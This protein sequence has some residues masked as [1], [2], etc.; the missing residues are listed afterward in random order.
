MSI[1][2]QENFNLDELEKLAAEIFAATPSPLA[3]IFQ[4]W[5]AMGADQNRR[6][7]KAVENGKAA[8]QQYNDLVALMR[9]QLD[10]LRQNW[11][12]WRDEQDAIIEE[13]ARKL[14][15]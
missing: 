12:H 13:V 11:Q 15:R 9:P 14:Q 6:W 7:D 2:N 3:P 5:D 10:L 8:A 4:I 1:E